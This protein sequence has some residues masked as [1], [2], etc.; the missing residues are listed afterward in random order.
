MRRN[1][2]IWLGLF[3]IV[4]TSNM[5]LVGCTST[6]NNTEP[7]TAIVSETAVQATKVTNVSAQEAHSLIQEK[8]DDPDFIIIDVRT[9]DEY[10]TGHA[11]GAINIDYNSDSFEDRMAELDK[12][13]EYLVYC[14]SGNRSSGAIKV[15]E[16][17][18]FTMIYHM[19]GGIIDWNAEG[20][21]F[22]R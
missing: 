9:P 2:L 8:Q 13:R 22:D 6:A 17:L 1:W 18:G 11:K 10:N 21:P 20:L 14:R 19:N 12:T 7:K 5:T 4:L 15:M 16:E 3:V